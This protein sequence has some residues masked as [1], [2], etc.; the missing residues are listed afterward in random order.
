MFR[1]GDVVRPKDGPFRYTCVVGEW[2]EP[3]GGQGCTPENS[4][5][6][7]AVKWGDESIW[8][9]SGGRDWDWAASVKPAPDADAVWADY[10]KAQ[11]LGETNSEA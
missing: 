9:V 10:V 5:V 11:L 3:Y 4:V 8:R 6:Y 7:E 2:R 1:P